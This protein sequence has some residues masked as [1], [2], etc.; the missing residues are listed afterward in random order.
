MAARRLSSPAWT[1][2]GETETLQVWRGGADGSTPVS[3]LA[4]GRNWIEGMVDAP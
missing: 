1:D 3:S 4:R 2:S